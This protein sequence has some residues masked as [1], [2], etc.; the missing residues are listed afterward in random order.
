MK[1]IAQLH[2][3]HSLHI[4]LYKIREPEVLE[5]WTQPNRLLLNRSENAM[6]IYVYDY[7]N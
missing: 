5:N 3:C 7:L 2:V 4:Y 6:L 1:A